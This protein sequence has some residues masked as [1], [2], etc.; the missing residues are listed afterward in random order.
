MAG[1]SFVT[2]FTQ[3]GPVSNIINAGM[4]PFDTS[5]INS[6]NG[7]DLVRQIFTGY[8]SSILFDATLTIPFRPITPGCKSFGSQCFSYVMPADLQYISFSSDAVQYRLTESGSVP[9]GSDVFVISNS[10]VYHFEYFP[11]TN[12]Y[13]FN[14]SDCVS[15]VT[16][17]PTQYNLETSIVTLQLC[18][19]N[20]DNF[21]IVVGTV[22][23][24]NTD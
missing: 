1:V 9:N 23:F 22:L 2:V 15:F 19:K 17:D 10:S 20:V 11:I 5:V 24:G 6:E 21:D 12:G 8:T 3:N 13:S 7:L 18:F 4:E 14:N 16:D